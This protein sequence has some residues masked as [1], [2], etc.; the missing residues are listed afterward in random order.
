MWPGAVRFGLGAVLVGSLGSAPAFADPIQVTGGQ[1]AL[2]FASSSFTFTG[3]GLSLS[4]QGD[5]IF[6]SL[7]LA[8]KPCSGAHP[9]TASFDSSTTG[10]L[11]SGG[12]PATFEGVTYPRA[13]FGADLAFTG[14]AFD[15]AR[16]S[17]SNLTFTAPFSM[18]ATLSAYASNPIFSPDPPIFVAP[19]FG[20]GTATAQFVAIPNG[21]RA[22][23]TLFDVT[24][25][26]YRFDAAAPTPEPASLLLLGTGLAALVAQRRRTA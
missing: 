13:T 20:S 16:L 23:H 6:S 19:L 10:L 8:C 14:P 15:T 26:V 1:F 9:E 24:S 7:F 5:A 22:G 25:L 2:S 18:T 12:L 4:G 21:D 11:A 17:P 3:D